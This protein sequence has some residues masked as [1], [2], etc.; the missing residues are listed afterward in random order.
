MARDAANYDFEGMNVTH[1]ILGTEKPTKLLV[2]LHG[3]G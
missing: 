2:L 3:G 1:M